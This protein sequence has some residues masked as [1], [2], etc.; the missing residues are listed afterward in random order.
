MIWFK[1]NVLY[2]PGC[3]T[4]F[5]LKELL[6]NYERLLSKLVD[7]IELKDLE[8]CC[9]SPLLNAGYLKEAKRIARKNLLTWKEHGVWKIITSCP[10]CYKV[11][12]L[13]YPKLLSSKIEVE[14]VVETIWRGIREGRLKF[15]K[16]K[17]IATYH[18][19]CHLGKYCGIYEE[20]RK[21]LESLGLKIEEMRF[22]KEKAFCCGGGGGLK[23]NFP[24]LSEEIARERV[25]QAT[26]TKVELLITSCPMCYLCLSDASKG[27]IEVR[28]I[29]QLFKF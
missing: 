5:F 6:S 25:K 20:P 8:I 23:G 28:E 17:G 26:Q 4:K 10:A 22:N 16:L 27:K 15:E 9:G 7:F 1:G 21:I 2:Y 12:K 13:D 19:P 3:L 24:E 11:F 18:D 29:S 14:H